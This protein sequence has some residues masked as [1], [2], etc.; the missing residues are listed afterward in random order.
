MSQRYQIGLLANKYTPNFLKRFPS[1][2]K[3]PRFPV[4]DLVL[5]NPRK[6]KSSSG[7]TYRYNTDE[8]SLLTHIRK[9]SFTNPFMHPAEKQLSF[10]ALACK[11]YIHLF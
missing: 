10:N 6:K 7:G 9:H 11:V 3:G 5:S 4:K 1:F 2:K 8:N